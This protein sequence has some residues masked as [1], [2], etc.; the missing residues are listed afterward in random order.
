MYLPQELV[1]VRHGE[2]EGNVANKASRA[3]DH[4]HFNDSFLVRP[5]SSW[6]LSKNGKKQAEKAGAWLR[7]QKIVNFDYALFSPFYRT[8]ETLFF[9]GESFNSL[10][11]GETH[12]IQERSW[13]LMDVLPVHEREA[14]FPGELAK[15]DI[16]PMHWIP[17]GGESIAQVMVRFESF[18]QLLPVLVPRA[19]R[20]LLV[21]HGELMWAARCVL[22]N[23][24]PDE[25]F[26]LH[27]SKDPGDKIY[28]CHVLH[29]RKKVS[30]QRY[31]KL[32]SVCTYNPDRWDSKWR[33][34]NKE[35][36]LA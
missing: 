35:A 24:S 12:F 14:K 36:A 27:H 6:H 25:Y 3:G 21:V 1:L 28:N 4:S 15:R 10:P 8:S 34:I 17:P 11:Q 23:I 22:E 2:S 29:Y 5:S 7:K 30:E 18:L 33:L 31:S 16:D 26:K 9:M 13:G 32:R 19:E 20:L